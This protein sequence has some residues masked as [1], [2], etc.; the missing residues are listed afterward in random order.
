M[1]MFNADGSEGA[2]CGNAIRCVAKYLFDNQ[3][4]AK[5]PI[6]IETKSGIKTIDYHPERSEATVAMGRARVLSK[7][8]VT[9]VDVG[10]PHAVLFCND[11][12]AIDVHGIG[13]FIERS[14]Y[15]VG[16][17]N[18]EFVQIVSP[19]R[20][21]MR[22]WERGSGETMACGTGSCASVVA[23]IEH[24]FCKMDTDVAVE[25]LGGELTIRVTDGGIFM[26]GGCTHVFSGVIE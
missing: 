19:T 2:M 14:P 17:V 10:N 24:G 6:S 8:F 9:H 1:R 3:I 25:L 7:G 4:V 13:A 15:F 22:V 18:V 12:G 11:V 16:G 20:I 21:K 5:N 26:T 23:C